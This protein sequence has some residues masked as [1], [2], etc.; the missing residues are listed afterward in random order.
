M[1]PILARGGRLALY[2]GVWIA[3]GV[4]LASLIGRPGGPGSIEGLAVALP[5]AIVY[6]FFCLSTWYVSRSAPLTN[7]GTIRLLVSAL[8]SALITSAV[9][10][11]LARVWIE[12]LAGRGVVADAA[13][14]FDRND[15]VLFGFGLLLYLLSLAGSYLLASFELS[16]EAERRALEGRVLAREAELRSLRA[17]IDPH[18][19]F[20]SLHSISALTTADPQAARRMCVLLADFLRE[21]LA[22]GGEERIP[23]GRELDLIRRYLDIEQ[24]RFGERLRVDLDAGDAAACLV[25][26]LLLQP[27]VENAVTHGIA[28]AIDGGVVRVAASRGEGTVTFTVENP[29]DP[30][31][32]RSAGTGLGLANV[33]ARLRALHGDD[34]RMRAGEEGGMWRVEIVLPLTPPPATPAV[35]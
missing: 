6:A 25:A 30:D 18:F 22:L 9:W 10:L 3:A 16:R 7:T 4:L 13:A 14:T 35:G 12:V 19:L 24:V 29:C 28:H 26:P 20:N 34:A 5:L 2:L 8:A 32:P 27:I 31:R 15:T 33:R 11:L 21:S 17:Q 23:I 1:H